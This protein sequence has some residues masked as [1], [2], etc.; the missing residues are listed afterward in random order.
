[1]GHPHAHWRTW[2]PVLAL[3]L[4][5]FPATVHPDKPLSVWKGKGELP[6]ARH[7]ASGAARTRCA[8]ILALMKDAGVLVFP[9]DR[10]RSH[11][12]PAQTGVTS[13]ALLKVGQG[14]RNVFHTSSAAPEVTGTGPFLH[15]YSIL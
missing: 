1:M 5:P 3:F 12:P 13:A 15:V 9:S 8:G 4:T 7:S 10:E 14:E 11:L 2:V 6:Q